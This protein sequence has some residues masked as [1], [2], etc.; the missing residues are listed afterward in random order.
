MATFKTQGIVL[1]R[2]NF[3]EYDRIFTVYTADCG[4]LR[5]TAASIR[6]IK[7]KQAG[8]MEPFSCV[9]LMIAHGRSMILRLA[10]G[11][12]RDVFGNIRVNLAKIASANHCLEVTDKAVSDE[13]PD[14]YVYEL[15]HETLCILNDREMMDS[16]TAPTFARLY[17]FKL[18]S[19]LGYTPEL[20]S[21]LICK[22][23]ITHEEVVFN[24]LHGGLVERRCLNSGVESYSLP[25]NQEIIRILN[26][27]L[28]Q[29][30][31]GVATIGITEGS[32]QHL[33]LI[34]K[35]FI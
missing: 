32:R 27:A 25:I 10:T 20:L 28:V 29:D 35:S 9:E 11:V 18:L 15:L 4:K 31:R 34:I 23:R 3:R 1:K 2:D 33:S 6:K 22:R 30:M 8:H 24:A 21:C 7:S 5:C 19:Y 16:S 26:I 17:A 12:T 14:R 13:H